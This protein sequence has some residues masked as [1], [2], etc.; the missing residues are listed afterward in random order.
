MNDIRLTPSPA[1]AGSPLAPTPRPHPP[2]C[3]PGRGQK[4]SS[5]GPGHHLLPVHAS[6][7]WNPHGDLGREV[8]L[9]PRRGE[10]CRVS[11]FAPLLIWILKPGLRPSRLLLQTDICMV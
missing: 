9:G 7:V 5:L 6:T 4:A 3:P 2:L 1:W 11:G 10:G 8:S